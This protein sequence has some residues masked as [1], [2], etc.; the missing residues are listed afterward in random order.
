MDN[1]GDHYDKVNVV[2]CCYGL[3][4]YSSRTKVEMEG[5]LNYLD[6]VLHLLRQVERNCHLGHVVVCGGKTDPN[7]SRSE[8]QTVVHMLETVLDAS[9]F[10]ADLRRD[11]RLHL[12]ERSRN[13][14]QNLWFA[15]DIRDPYW[16]D[17]AWIVCCDS[18][19]EQKVR[20]IAGWVSCLRFV[21]MPII[22]SFD[23]QDIHP[24]SSYKVQNRLAWLYRFFGPLLFLFRDL[25]AV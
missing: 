6:Q 4:L 5:Y 16:H 3:C 10:I 17:H 20:A 7:D 13:T 22:R 25:R 19:R 14:P 12:E 23:R 2:I 11:G 8:A 18:W 1:F 9:G 21:D 24:N 15:L